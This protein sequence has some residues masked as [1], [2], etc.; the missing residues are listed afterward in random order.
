M[1]H[2]IVV[3]E[4]GSS[5]YGAYSPDVPGCVATGAT[6][7]E[8]LREM[9]SALVFHFEGMLEAGEALPSPIGLQA[10]LLSGEYVADPGDLIAH[11]AAED[12]FR[13]IPAE[14]ATH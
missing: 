10:H 1:E 13:R 11:V 7:D 14:A 8:A 2:F 5:N 4:P 9:T 6:L 12:L 3:I